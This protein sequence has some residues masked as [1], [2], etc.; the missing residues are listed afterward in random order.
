MAA[1]SVLHVDVLNNPSQFMDDLIF[2]VIFETFQP[3]ESGLT[4]SVIYVGSADDASKDQVLD[5]VSFEG[6]DKGTFQFRLV[7]KAAD[8]TK[9][10][11]ID[12][13]GVTV[14]ML[15]GQYKGK[16]F[17]RYGYYVNVDYDDPL[18]RTDPR[19]SPP[20]PN[21]LTRTILDEKSVISKFPI[22]WNDPISEK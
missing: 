21:K 17:I 18:L 22:S 2:D 1:V 9:I 14:L 19:P 3:F 15:S 12:L 16:E 20:L 8:H 5:T 6:L 10:S 11:E 13:V 7:C 4:W